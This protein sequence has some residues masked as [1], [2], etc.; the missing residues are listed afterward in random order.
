MVRFPRDMEAGM[1]V[2]RRGAGAAGAAVLSSGALLALALTGGS[3]AAAGTVHA[4]TVS[5]AVPFAK[6]VFSGYGTG[7]EAHIGAVTLPGTSGGTATQVAGIDQA[8]SGAA[9]KFGGDGAGVGLS[10][11]IDSELGTVVAPGSLGGGVNAYGNGVGLQVG[12]GT[13]SPATSNTAQVQLAGLATQQAPPNGAPVVQS[14]GVPAGV[15]TAVASGGVLNGKATAF[16]DPTGCPLGQP[17]SYGLGNATDLN[18]LDL[19]ALTGQS[20]L[21]GG[22]AI[23]LSGPAGNGTAESTSYTYLNANGDGTYALASQST[24]TIAPVTVNVAGALQLHLSVVTADGTGAPAPVT[25][26]STTTG[27]ASGAKVAFSSAGIVQVSVTANGTTTPLVDVPLSDV[28]PTGLHIP[29][30]VAGL[31]TAVSTLSSTVSSVVSSVNQQ[32]GQTLTT[33]LQ[34][35]QSVTSQVT[36]ALGTVLSALPV[37]INL[38]SLDIDV[39]PHAIGQAATTPPTT[40]G[41]TSAGGALDLL[42]LT[43][44][45][46]ATINGTAVPTVTIADVALGHLE[47]MAA[48]A[49]PILCPLPIIKSV[50]KQSI[51]AGD[52]FV[53][54]IQVPDPAKLADLACDLSSVTAT[55]TITDYQGSPVFQV[56]GA[57]NNGTFTPATASTNATVTWTGLS[58]TRT[59][60]PAA[61]A[62]PITL[63]VNVSTPASSPAGVIQDLVSATG[64]AANCKDFATGLTNLGGINGAVLAGSYT[65]QAPSVSAAPTAPAPT[66]TPPQLPHTGG[67]GG[68]WQPLGGLGALVL[69]GGALWALR[70]S[71]RLTP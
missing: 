48:T 55:D 13:S 23:Q 1:K 65:L 4:A 54:T 68:L 58:Y 25:L 2:R 36:G 56:T 67:T 33:A 51:T 10:T 22:P 40:T 32:A 44:A 39:S 49:A 31:Q 6:A 21:S 35:V 69:G 60:P 50:D 63:T 47:T 46:Q 53:Y 64:T 24:E 70:R 38:G 14:A 26:T 12:L 34:G 19:G 11:T 27:E 42:H 18:A 20:S 62:P 57:S 45:P 59:V 17:I 28:G 61:A 30:S 52:S 16:F 3:A 15:P 71:R 43:V 29:L 66:S 5:G 8:F 9:T 37:D 41:G 7:T